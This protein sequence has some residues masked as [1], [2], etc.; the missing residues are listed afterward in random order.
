MLWRN[1]GYGY[2]NNIITVSYMKLFWIFSQFRIVSF[3]AMVF[4]GI[5]KRKEC[6]NYAM[7]WWLRILPILTMLVGIVKDE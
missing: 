6:G 1:F 3:A 5:G 4:Q 2:Y 7:W